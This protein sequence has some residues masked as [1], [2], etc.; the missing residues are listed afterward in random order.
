MERRNSDM[1]EF[2]T[3]QYC[4]WNHFSYRSPQ[5]GKGWWKNQGE[6]KVSFKRAE[7]ARCCKWGKWRIKW[8]ERDGKIGTTWFKT[9][10]EGKS[11]GLERVNGNYRLPQTPA[12]GPKET[13]DSWISG[14]NTKASELT[15]LT[16]GRL[17]RC[18]AL[19][20]KTPPLKGT[21]AIVETIHN[22]SPGLPRWVNQSPERDRYNSAHA[23]TERLCHRPGTPALG[24]WRHG[25][26][27]SLFFDVFASETA[28]LNPCYSKWVHGRATSTSPRS[29]I[30]P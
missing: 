21:S 15:S 24:S 11:G 19:S 16:A 2:K 10:A 1:C 8:H 18:N 23:H 17:A 28:S 7:E 26:V 22:N 14:C 29:C 4:N 9:T 3:T 6:E 5:K 13:A 20:H 25:Q 12:R 30:D 27:P